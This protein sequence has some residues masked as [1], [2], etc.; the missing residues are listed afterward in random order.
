MAELPLALGEAGWISGGCFGQF[1][2]G[3]WIIFMF[4][5][6]LSISFFRLVF[7]HPFQAM[8][9]ELQILGCFL[10]VNELPR[11]GFFC[12][13][14][15]N[16]VM[17]T[18]PSYLADKELESFQKLLKFCIYRGLCRHKI[19]AS[20]CHLFTK[21]LPFP[22]GTAAWQQESWVPAIPAARAGAGR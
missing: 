9:L 18:L 13:D 3:M 20:A 14:S 21:L 16:L 17:T 2:C 15:C 11:E 10:C 8:V 5:F 19:P 4:Y 7:L 12:Q 6:V 22:A 1:C